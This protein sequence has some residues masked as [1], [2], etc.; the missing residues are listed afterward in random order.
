MKITLHTEHEGRLIF[1]DVK[2]VNIEKDL[3]TII[4]EIRDQ[5]LKTSEISRIDLEVK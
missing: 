5:Y 4:G 3:I 1:N 2:S